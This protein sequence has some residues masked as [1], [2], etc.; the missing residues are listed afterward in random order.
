MFNPLNSLMTVVV[1]LAATCVF[2]QPLLYK[3]YIFGHDVFSHFLWA[4]Q[5][6]HS[7]KEGVVYPQWV[8][9]AN[10]G[11]GNASFIFY[12]PF[13]FYSYALAGLF[14]KKVLVML[15]ASSFIGIFASGMA[16]Y[17]FCR[18]YMG[19]FASLVASLVYM[20][21]PYHL[22][23]LYLRAAIAELWSFFWIPLICYFLAKSR[24]NRPA[25]FAGVSVSF[26]GLLMTH[27]PTA[28]LFSPF[29]LF[30]LFLLLWTEREGKLFLGRLVL[31]GLGAGLSALY[32]IPALLEQQYVNINALSTPERYQIINNFL[33]SRHAHALLFNNLVSRLAV[34]ITLLPA[35]ALFFLLYRRKAA[36]EGSFS[37]G[38]F[39]ASSALF[40]FLLMLPLSGAFWNT[41]PFFQRVQFPWRVLLMTTFY[42]SL[43]L[44]AVTEKLVMDKG[45]HKWT[46]AA[47]GSV[48]IC[49]IAVNGFYSYKTMHLFKPFAFDFHDSLEKKGLVI[50]ADTPYHNLL[51]N[52]NLYFKG[53]LWLLDV[54]EYRPIWSVVKSA[55]SIPPYGKEDL[56]SLA[57]FMGLVQRKIDESPE[58]DFSSE[59][60]GYSEMRGSNLLFPQLNLLRA[61]GKAEAAVMIPP[62]LWDANVFLQDVEGKFSITRW[63]PEDRV[64]HMKASKGGNVLLKLFYYPRWK[65]Y[66]NGR[67]IAINPQPETGLVHMMIPPGEYD[68]RLIFEKGIFRTIGVTVSMI[69][70]ASLVFFVIWRAR[71]KRSALR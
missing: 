71:E 44:G 69:S 4:Q 24:E 52:Y 61:V 70:A 38:I 7:I 30:Y 5:F 11:C 17:L 48:I 39:F 66:I 58:S 56:K 45:S 51:K 59:M 40:S 41:V 53:N 60:R 16:M 22:V 47:T 2:C 15:S 31:L 43:S 65:A 13:T 34:I 68:I 18:V 6:V 8:A 64:I 57:E 14:T 67:N 42:S 32:L 10:F 3:G 49:I 9:D 1:V 33:F 46:S 63:E 23:D 54:L 50:R 21:A 20:G 28:L 27:M 55:G 19:R 29:L 12:P 35:V 26:A 62:Q 25:Y 36:G 37:S